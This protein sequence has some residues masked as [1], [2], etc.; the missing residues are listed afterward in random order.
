[1]RTKVILSAVL[2]AFLMAACHTEPDTMNNPF[3]SDY[4]TPYG[5]PP[6]NK[7]INGHYLPALDSA[8]TLHNQEIQAIINNGSTPDFENTLVALDRSGELLSKV[9]SVFFGLYSADGT[10]ELKSISPDFRA[11]VSSHSDDIMLNP[12]LFARINAVREKQDVLQLNEEQLSLLDKY[13]KSFVRHGVNL[14]E[15][16]KSRLRQIN[17]RLTELTTRFD[18]NLL[19]ETNNFS[20]VIEHEEDLAGLPEDVIRSAASTAKEKGLEG[21]W[22]FTAHKPSM[23]PFLQYAQNRELRK[24]LY[25]AY[26]MRGDNDNEYDNKDIIAEMTLL[27]LEKANL[28][29]FPSFAAYQLDNKMAKT[30]EAVFGFLDKIWAAALPVAASEREDMQAII[31]REGGNFQLAPEDWWYYAEKLRKEKYD[32][33]DNELKPY[34][35]LNHVINGVFT[36]SNKLYGIRFEKLESDIPKPHPD[37]EAFKVT[38]ADGSFLGIL[39]MD[40]FTRSTKAQGAWCG[41]YRKQYKTDTQEVRPVV[42]IVT[43]YANPV[44]D[45]PVLLSLDQTLTLFHEFG[46]GLHNLLSDVHYEGIACTSVK[47]DFVELPSQIMENWATEPDVLKL[48]AKHYK[49]GMQMPDSLIDK[50]VASASF[51]QGF[52]TVELVAAS[53]LDMKYHVLNQPTDLDIDRFEKDY[54]DKIGLIPEIISRYRSTYF[55]HI[56]SSGYSAGYYS[57]LWAEVLDKDAFN[58]FLEHGLFDPGTA[59]AFRTNILEKGGSGEPMEMYIRFRGQEPSVEPLLKGRGLL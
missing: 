25:D 43:N 44:G 49:T 16:E 19:A 47:R 29:G 14:P 30:P 38:D 18:N 26:C 5:V 23:I 45:E 54:F 21:K 27:R 37:A 1:M 42:T 12:E 34:F 40:Y 13:Y 59:Q 31:D 3:F 8:I 6:F 15:A 39:Y 2:V 36:V 11:R 28:L 46:H 20:L 17:L 4:T 55:K 56:W 33:D 10:D 48:F 57:Y 32:L 50:L 52:E 9:T 51:N 24:K 35:E 58:A 41:T 7:I 22:V 53:Y